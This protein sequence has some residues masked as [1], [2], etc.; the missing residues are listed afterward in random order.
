M[1]SFYLRLLRQ[2]PGVLWQTITRAEQLFSI[3]AFIVLIVLP[4]VGNLKGLEDLK[5]FDRRWAVLPIGM[6]LI[7]GLLKANYQAYHQ[8]AR[9]RDEAVA[10]VGRARLDS[11]RGDINRAKETRELRDA[12]GG[13]LK[14]GD[15]LFRQQLTEQ[16]I[17]AWIGA[18][19]SWH[20]QVHEWL[21]RELGP[22][23]A[24]LFSSTS[25]G[26]SMSYNHSVSRKHDLAL[27]N[28]KRLLD[29]LRSLM[30]RI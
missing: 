13:Y 20:N 25:G 29:N 22:G 30:N 1:L 26:M 5:G 4:W 3:L 24:A 18:V 12:L 23:E 17:D 27:G 9:E 10:A 28:L 2:I 7:H 16:S 15:A 19:E 21:A 6:L 8:V 11:T 14:S